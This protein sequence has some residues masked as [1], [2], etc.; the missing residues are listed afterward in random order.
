MWEIWGHQTRKTVKCYKQS[1]MG[2]SSRILKDSN[3]GSYADYGDPAQ[4]VSEG[5]KIS[6]WVRHRPCDSLVKSAFAFILRTC[7]KLSLNVMD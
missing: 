7:L 3:A 4:E 1:L 2:H 6:N 5:N